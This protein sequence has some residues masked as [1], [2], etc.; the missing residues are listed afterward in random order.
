MLQ[1]SPGSNGLLTVKEEGKLPDRDVPGTPGKPTVLYKAKRPHGLTM[2]S[3][4]HVCI[5]IV[6]T[7]ILS[8]HPA[9]RNAA[10][11]TF[12]SATHPYCTTRE[13]HKQHG[14]QTAQS[15]DI[16]V[17]HFSLV[18]GFGFRDGH[19]IVL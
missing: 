15:Q 4:L 5:R 7:K 6:H 12:L 11:N 1:F 8:L 10:L 14:I 9:S 13:L 19:E 3:D 2:R 18:K 16:Q 17:S